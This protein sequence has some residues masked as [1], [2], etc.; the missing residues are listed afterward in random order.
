MPISS[1][2]SID[3]MFVAGNLSLVCP[4]GP[5]GNTL[6]FVVVVATRN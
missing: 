3:V 2:I 6:R 4:N 5:C 1:V